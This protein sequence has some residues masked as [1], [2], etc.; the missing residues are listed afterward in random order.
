MTTKLGDDGEKAQYG[1]HPSPI[2]HTLCSCIEPHGMIIGGPPR[3]HRPYDGGIDVCVR[4][5]PGLVAS[6]RQ[7]GA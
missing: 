3:R 1:D 2:Q 5:P 4:L 6:T 7:G